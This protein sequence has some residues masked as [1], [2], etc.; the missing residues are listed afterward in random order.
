MKSLTFNTVKLIV[1]ALEHTVDML[2]LDT[3]ESDVLTY[4]CLE[5]YPYILK[6]ELEDSH[7]YAVTVLQHFH[8]AVDR[9]RSMDSYQE[10]YDIAV[11]K[12]IEKAINVFGKN[13]FDRDLNL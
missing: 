12:I 7:G 13:V 10:N 11:E 2:D 5:V 4:I 6:C 1:P 9:F 8:I 3:F